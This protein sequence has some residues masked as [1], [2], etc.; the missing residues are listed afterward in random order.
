MI[1]P[2]EEYTCRWQA[3]DQPRP[4]GVGSG[5][6]AMITTH[7]HRPLI[8]MATDSHK[9]YF[10]KEALM[11]A[12]HGS[13]VPHT[14]GPHLSHLDLRANFV[15]ATPTAMTG[16]KSW[17]SFVLGERTMKYWYFQI[18][19]HPQKICF[20]FLAGPIVIGNIFGSLHKYRGA[21]PTPFPPTHTSPENAKKLASFNCPLMIRNHSLY[22]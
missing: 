3:C 19:G 12:S 6:R 22:Q 13:G 1:F 11:K 5:A 18:T 10:F 4:S 9:V 2:W 21:S 17:W 14:C 8:V 15:I 20:V 16:Y 7:G